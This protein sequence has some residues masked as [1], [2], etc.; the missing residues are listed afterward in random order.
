M[1]YIVPDLTKYFDTETIISK[2]FS[3]D[4][5]SVESEPYSTPV[6]IPESNVTYR[7]NP[8]TRQQNLRSYSRQDEEYVPPPPHYRAREQAQVTQSCLCN[9]L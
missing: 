4:H 9:I 8:D 1:N 7:G 2:Q 3:N 6:V 5:I